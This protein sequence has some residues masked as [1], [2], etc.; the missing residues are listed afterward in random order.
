MGMQIPKSEF[1]RVAIAVAGFGVLAFGV[2]LIVVPVPG[3][4]VVL[5]P[6]GLAILAREF[7]WARRLLDWSRVSARR[8]CDRARQVFGGWSMPRTPVPS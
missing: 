8:L 2:A 4:T 5:I 6:L 3:T 1:R 7:D